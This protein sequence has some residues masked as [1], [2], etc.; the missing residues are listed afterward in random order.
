MTMCPVCYEIYGDL[1]P[2]P[3]DICHS[4]TISVSVELVRIVKMF[5][6]RGFKVNFANCSTYDDKLR[7]GKITQIKID[8]GDLYPEALLNDLPPD[9]LITYYHRVYYQK[10]STDKYTG[11]SCACL[12]PE[13]ECDDDCVDFD[14][15]LT[16]QNLESW[17]GEKDIRACKAVLLLTGC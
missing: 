5:I 13:G 7:G 12:H 2:L 4:I 15:I 17:L 14:V 9:W 1:W 11:L 6:I 3:C 10:I 8:F 16:I